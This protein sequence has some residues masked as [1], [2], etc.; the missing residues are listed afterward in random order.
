[1]CNICLTT[2][3][4]CKNRHALCKQTHC[5][6]LL[7][8]LLAPMIFPPVMTLALLWLP[9]SDPT[10]HPYIPMGNVS[11]DSKQE[12]HPLSSVLFEAE[13]HLLWA[14]WTATTHVA[15]RGGMWWSLVMH[16]SKGSIYYKTATVN[17]FKLSQMRQATLLETTVGYT[18]TVK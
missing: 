4:T 16:F 15:K 2:V 14:L 3:D 17:H 18:R 10:S 5:S 7:D 13:L 9:C 6:S 11:W 1:M 8:L 12:K